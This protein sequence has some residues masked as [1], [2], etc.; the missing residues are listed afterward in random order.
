MAKKQ[1]SI[2]KRF[3]LTGA[4]LSAFVFALIY[5]AN[6]DIHRSSDENIAII[7]HMHLFGQ[8]LRVIVTDLQTIEREIYQQAITPTTESQATIDTAYENLL[9]RSNELAA[10][11]IDSKAPVQ[12]KRPSK[13]TLLIM[14]L[15]ADIVYIK[16]KLELFVEN[17][18]DV[19][20]RYPGMLILTKHL[21]PANNR[22]IEAANLAID[23]S[24]QKN[25]SAS[26][27][28][29]SRKIETLFHKVRYAWAQQ[30]SWVRLFIANRSGVFGDAEKSMAVSLKNRQLYL[31]Q[32]KNILNRLNK[33]ENSDQLD[34]QQSQSLED[35]NKIINEYEVYF[36]QARKMYRS[37]KWRT[38]LSIL[39]NDLRPRFSSM[40]EY[41][42]Q[43]QAALES[44]TESG[45]LIS[46]NTTTELSRYIQLVG[47]AVIIL[48]I[49][50]YLL[51]EYSLRKPIVQLSQALDSE[52]KGIKSDLDL[53]ET[54]L[55][56]V[57]LVDAFKNM[58]QQVH[59]RQTRLQSVLESVGEGIVTITENGLIEVFNPA[60]EILFGYTQKEVLGKN[61]SILLPDDPAKKH[62]IYLDNFSA[63]G[64]KGIIGV[65]REVNAKHKGG[66]VFPMSLK[67]TEMHIEGKRYY[68]AVVDN[69]S[70]R[71]NMIHNLQRL[72]EHDSLT[73]LYNRHFF[74][75]ELDKVMVRAKR[76]IPNQTALLYLDLDNFKY[77]ND[78]LGHLAGDQLIVEVAALINKRTRA[79][80][81]LA[82]LGGDE[83]AVLLHR[84][85]AFCINTI[86]E[87]FCQTLGN[88]IFKYKGKVVDISASIGAAIIT[89]DIDTKEELLARADFSCH[90]AKRLGR[91]RIHVYTENDGVQMSN[92][93]NDI[94]WTRKIKNALENDQFILVCQPIVDTV[95]KAVSHS[96]VLIRMRQDD[97][98]LILPGGFLPAAERFGLMSKID[99]W[100]VEHALK[101]L[102]SIHTRDPKFKFS[103]NLSASSLENAHI[104]DI[105]KSALAKW[106][107][108]PDALL[109]E[110]TETVAMNNLNTA[111]LMLKELQSM[112]CQ[113]ALDDF[114][115]GYSSF[116]YLKELPVDFVKIDGSFVKDID[117]N[118]LNKAMVRAINDIAHELGKKTIAEFVESENILAILSEL[119]VDYAQ[120]FHLGR[121]QILQ[122]GDDITVK[123]KTA[124]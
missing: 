36:E 42:H 50:G 56:T 23:E 91:N 88:F 122:T 54:I 90:E 48:L 63:H 77:V 107:I 39:Q 119:N 115:V 9:K 124:P 27:T 69:I 47:L 76:D 46:Q 62:Q 37:D 43:I 80:D 78:T 111:S 53:N 57:V 10:Y 95:S 30:I 45:L 15:Y 16:P 35:M 21:L 98:E 13:F 24:E 100:V 55:E 105:I 64:G 82:R 20:R 101:L 104:L 97:G 87:S 103:I 108:P 99:D 44:H 106:N 83:F 1:I 118:T 38:D 60:A 18:V 65:G 22:F 117:T 67:V 7:K 112:G 12:N 102:A 2:K 75:E 28:E 4:I 71:K 96:E 25:T 113:T 72:A 17:S 41:I 84:T 5:K 8:T 49:V 116:T 93:S 31:E 68:T 14:S 121:P 85:D 114:G 70:E 61:M 34:L 40:R 86:A 59:S 74:M 11:T 109:F 6:L 52:A 73:G 123:S 33:Y 66:T 89:E 19:Q 29:S 79:G 110:V 81:I 51:F 94:G 32:V 58:Q 92:L 26:T 3:L 120:G